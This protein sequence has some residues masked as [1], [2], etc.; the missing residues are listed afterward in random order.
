MKPNQSSA[1]DESS[2]DRDQ[3]DPTVDNPLNSDQASLRDSIPPAAP[4]PAAA[5]DGD[6]QGSP[7]PLP[8]VPLPPTNAG[9][10]QSSAREGSQPPIPPPPTVA[11]PTVGA[12]PIP[13][14]APFGGV[15][16]GSSAGHHD[17]RGWRATLVAINLAAIVI[18]AIA[19]TLLLTNSDDKNVRTAQDLSE[20]TTTAKPTTTSPAIAPETTNVPATTAAPPTPLPV[21]DPSTSSPSRAQITTAPTSPPPTDPPPTEP[22]PPALPSAD[23]AL[24][25]AQSTIEAFLAADSNNQI[26]E[27]LGYLMEP[28]DT[29]VD[30]SD[31]SLGQVREDVDGGKSDNTQ[32][33]ILGDVTL[34]SG[35]Q[36]SDLGAW[37]ATVT[38]QLQATGSF[39]S[40]K[41][42]G[43]RCIN[44][45]QQ[46]EDRIVG[47]PD[48]DA[49][50]KGHRRVE[51]L[52]NECAN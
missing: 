38:Y 32:L 19:V 27:A 40:Q 25:T 6:Q 47:S 42:Q 1:R 43:E 12:T 48:G 18:T 29:W 26:D 23:E 8:P 52:S 30:K 7:P 21:P 33:S 34:T 20:S 49:W 50:I 41:Y 28:L 4:F 46:I 13:P 36:T 37:E 51:E 16:P 17:L 22:P 5:T 2:D 35:P 11:P 15:A 45:V 31:Q 10:S 39:Y 9:S 3:S 14:A 24:S 44:N